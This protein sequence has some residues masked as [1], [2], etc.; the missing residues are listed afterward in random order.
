MVKGTCTVNGTSNKHAGESTACAR[1]RPGAPRGFLFLPFYFPCR[2]A[3]IHISRLRGKWN[4]Q[5]RTEQNRTGATRERRDCSMTPCRLV[6]GAL[7][8]FN[9][10]N[11]PAWGLQSKNITEQNRTEQNRTEQNRTEQ[12]RYNIHHKSLIIILHMHPHPTP[13]HPTFS[14]SSS[15]DTP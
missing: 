2:G 15:T 3:A 4:L 6:E 13:P 7:F 1:D 12:I 10:P 5:N 8:I 14:P 9:R 11:A